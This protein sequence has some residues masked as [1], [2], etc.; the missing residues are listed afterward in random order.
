[1]PGLCSQGTLNSHLLLVGEQM[2]ML[3]LE[4]QKLPLR[5]GVRQQLLPPGKVASLVTTPALGRVPCG[6]GEQGRAVVH[7]ERAVQNPSCV[8]LRSP[9]PLTPPKVQ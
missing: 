4:P 2:V 5:W 7:S 3:L 9:L 1:M 8:H 6:N